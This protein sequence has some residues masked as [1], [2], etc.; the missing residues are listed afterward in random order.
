MRQPIFI[1]SGEQGEGKT[2]TL[3]NV[4]Q[5][6]ITKGVPVKGFTAPGKWKDNLRSRFFIKDLAGGE[7]KLLCQNKPEMGFL[8]TGRFY[9]NLK[10]I[11]YGEQILLAAKPQELL[12]IDEVGMFEIKGYI[13]GP[14]LQ[15]IVSSKKYPLIIT[16]R[17]SF[18]D[19]VIRH[20]KINYAFV[21]GLHE[22]PEDISEKIMTKLQHFNPVK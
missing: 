6:L 11:E 15:Q 20:F 14:V 7:S 22:N 1:I 2:T 16:V 18:V 5:L 17:K 8:K 13:W 3:E 21:F 10:G 19:E 12:V 9:F 4:M